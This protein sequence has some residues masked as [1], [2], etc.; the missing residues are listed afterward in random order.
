MIL[1]TE[2]LIG[3]TKSLV[4]VK[5]TKEGLLFLLDDQAAFDDLIQ[6]LEHFLHGDQQT[7]FQGPSVPITVDYGNRILTS[8]QAS[9]LLQLFLGRDNL[10]IKEWGSHTNARQSLFLNRIRGDRQTILKGTVR[11]GQKL[12]YDGDVVVIG[13]V[14]PGGEIVST[15]DVYVF[16]RLRGIAH[17]GV[18]GDVRAVVAAMEF[19]PMQLRIAGVV[20]HVPEVNGQTL[21]SYMEF[22]YL[23]DGGMAV[24]KMEFFQ[25][26]KL[27]HRD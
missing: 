20:G 8:V 9:A 1:N 12:V 2:S 16:G 22:A 23:R 17:A 13:D 6:F 19:M 21:H 3:E 5:G 27:R 11:A 18:N 7:M 24:D 14:N 4:T 15:G 26:Q 25:A 10:L